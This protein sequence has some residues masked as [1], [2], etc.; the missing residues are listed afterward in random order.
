MIPS[1]KRSNTASKKEKTV[2]MDVSIS[3]YVYSIIYC[4][5]IHDKCFIRS[6]S[7]SDDSD[8]TE[9]SDQ[10]V[11]QYV[12]FINFRIIIK[13]YTRSTEVSSTSKNSKKGKGK[14]VEN[15]ESEEEDRAI[16]MADIITR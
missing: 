7:V 2:T 12:F 15:S 6:I 9:K 13:C 8:V 14:K 5:E 16:V 10:D 11:F 3:K 4:L 1:K